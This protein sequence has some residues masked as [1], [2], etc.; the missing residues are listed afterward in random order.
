MSE[1]NPFDPFFAEIRKIVR[2]EIA[3]ALNE[4]K[5]AKLRF[6]LKEAAAALNCKPSWLASK[7]RQSEQPQGDGFP[8]ERSGRLIYFTQQDLDEIMSRSVVSPNNGKT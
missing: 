7:V 3:K 4:R 8:H 2:E 1:P 5:P 6:T